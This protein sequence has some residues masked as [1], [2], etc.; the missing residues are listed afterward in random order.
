MCAW[1]VARSGTPRLAAL[2]VLW[3]CL[4]A[5]AGP[6]AEPG[7]PQRCTLPDLEWTR[8]ETDGMERLR[9]ESDV[10]DDGKPDLLVGE[11]SRGSELG[12]DSVVLTLSSTGERIEASVEPDYTSLVGFLEVPKA[13]RRPGRECARGL[14]E[15]ALFGGVRPQADP[16]LVWLLDARHRLRWIPGPPRLPGCYT[17]RTGDSWTTY[18]GCRLEASGEKGQ[19]P[20]WELA[21][22]HDRVLY[23]MR[24]AVVL[25]DAARSRHAWLTVQTD[26]KRDRVVS[27]RF[28]P[29]GVLVELERWDE[30]GLRVRRSGLTVDL[31]TGAV[32]RSRLRP[33][34]AASSPPGRL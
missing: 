22:D 19:K 6:A 28:D 4:Q 29:A 26:L 21:R 12:L 7:V 17:I 1:K 34:S 31:E 2:L 23:G 25:F 33:S 9:A 11:S 32:R 24:W 10:D 3:L 18:R 15:K 8:D 5:P 14:V 27:A 30:A 16:S 13:L 20:P